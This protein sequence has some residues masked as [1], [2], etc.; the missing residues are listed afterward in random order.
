MN[1]LVRLA[2][3]VE[4]RPTIEEV[5]AMLVELGLLPRDQIV[6]GLIDDLLDYRARLGA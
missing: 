3:L 1:A 6:T 5:D 2:A 4:E